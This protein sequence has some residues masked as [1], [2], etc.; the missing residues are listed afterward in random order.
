MLQF[1]SL[2]ISNLMKLSYI[3]CKCCRCTL[4]ELL[5]SFL[6]FVS[7]ICHPRNHNR[8]TLI[9]SWNSCRLVYLLYLKYKGVKKRL[10]Q[11]KRAL[12]I[13]HQCRILVHNISM[14]YR[15]MLFGRKVPALPVLWLG[16]HHLFHL[17]QNYVSHKDKEVEVVVIQTRRPR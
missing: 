1:K 6:S 11:I 10:F 13:L 4:V 14:N 12:H 2:L 9:H 5:C 7:W 15:V 3:T 16:H 8:C 17:Q